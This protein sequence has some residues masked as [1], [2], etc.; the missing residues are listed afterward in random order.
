MRDVATCSLFCLKKFNF[1]LT[2]VI[3]RKGFLE[4]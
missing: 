1:N 3:L 2:N 4:S